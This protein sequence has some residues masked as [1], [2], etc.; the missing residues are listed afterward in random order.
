MNASLTLLAI[1][2]SL[3]ALLWLSFTDPKRRRSFAR[4]AYSG[5]RR[6]GLAWTVALL[7]GLLLPVIAGGPGV[8]LWFGALT[9]TGWAL[10]AI[11][12]GRGGALADRLDRAAAW[13]GG[14]LDTWGRGFGAGAAALRSRLARPSGAA[15]AAP[16]GVADRV[17][18]LERKVMALETEI[19]RL[20]HGAAEADS[21]RHVE[22][23]GARVA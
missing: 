1:A 13:V 7:P 12:P 18:E 15:P 9:V 5:P 10:I 14:R 3:A 17:A 20:R 16:S 22:P 4:P 21:A 2:I 11:P 19:A 8:V 6:T 23:K